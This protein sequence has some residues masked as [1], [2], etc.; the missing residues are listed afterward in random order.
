MEIQT[1]HSMR[2]AFKACP[3]KI[4]FR[5]IAGI[6]QKENKSNARLIGKTFHNGL[7]MLRNGNTYIDTMEHLKTQLLEKL[8]DIQTS[9]ELIKVGSYLTGYQMAFHDDWDE[10]N[11]IK[12]EFK[13]GDE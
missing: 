3:R 4:Y 13:L 8:G 1:S 11:T 9:V 12:T 10:N 5:Y 2:S 7:E 6:Q